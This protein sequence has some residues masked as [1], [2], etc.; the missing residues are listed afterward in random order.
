MRQAR[1]EWPDW[2]GRQPQEAVRP[3]GPA[4]DPRLPPP[5]ELRRLAAAGLTFEEIS[6]AVHR[7]GGAGVSQAA[8]E[9]AL[10]SA[11]MTGEALTSYFDCLPWR[12]RPEH[13]GDPSAAM[14]RLVGRRRVGVPLPRALCDRVDAWLAELAQR[15]VV[16]AYSPI[17]GFV[18]VPES[19]RSGRH[20]DLPI[21]VQL[22]ESFAADSPATGLPVWPTSS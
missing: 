7:A 12:I 8:L 1:G 11:C 4:G 15:R 17:D 22:L 18:L 9:T 19:M 3:P 21:R 2:P 6:D 20:R 13:A 16:V 14:L 5:G 10:S